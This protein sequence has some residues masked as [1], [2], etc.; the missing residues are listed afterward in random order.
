MTAFFYTVELVG[1]IAFAISGSTVGVNKKLDIFGVIV[2]GLTTA[3][4]GGLIRDVILDIF[5]P[6]LFVK[7][8]YVL[9]ALAA[10]VLTFIYSYFRSRFKKSQQLRAQLLNIVD[11]I[12]LGVFT[13]SGINTA[14][15]VCTDE[16]AFLCICMGVMTGVGGGLVRDLL[17]NQV[18]FILY[19]RVYAVASIL[20]A[21]LYFY[22]ERIK[23]NSIIAVSSAVA[24]VVA[25]RIAATVWKIDLPRVRD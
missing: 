20:G 11:A 19:K 21:V 12:G 13:V 10:S 9:A 22:L 6:M 24:L 1:T 4:G 18:P 14:I 16:N 5:P 3:V 17:S 25:I 7:V 15:R 23:V 8:E 2:L